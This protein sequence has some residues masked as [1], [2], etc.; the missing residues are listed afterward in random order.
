MHSPDRVFPGDKLVDLTTP[1]LGN[2]ESVRQRR[3]AHPSDFPAVLRLHHL[4]AGFGQPKG[5]VR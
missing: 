4:P 5:P 3:Q 1:P 2:R